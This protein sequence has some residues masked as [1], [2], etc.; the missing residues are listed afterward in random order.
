MLGSMIGS[1]FVWLF[2]KKHFD[3]TKDSK[4]KKAVFCTMPAI[5]D[6]YYNLMSEII[7]TF[8]LLFT[9]LNFTQT[10]I[11]D[12]KEVIGLGSL[13]STPASLL[14]L[15][16]DLSIGGTTGYAITTTRFRT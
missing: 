4:S 10:I 6:K 16:I 14:V 13:G 7:G 12:T 5:W 2:Y 11:L 3:A 8:I 15:A 9:I 1:L